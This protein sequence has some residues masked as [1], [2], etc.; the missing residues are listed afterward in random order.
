MYLDY[1]CYTTLSILVSIYL[2]CSC[3]SQTVSHADENQCDLSDEE[4]FRSVSTLLSFLS[5]CE[6]EAD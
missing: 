2:S 6:E 4:D 1:R 5:R 3:F